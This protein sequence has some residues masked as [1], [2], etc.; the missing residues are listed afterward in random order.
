MGQPLMSWNPPLWVTVWVLG[1]LGCPGA[2]LLSTL[3]A[4]TIVLL[5]GASLLGFGII[6]TVFILGCRVYPVVAGLLILR[7]SRTYA[8]RRAW[9]IL[10]IGIAGLLIIGGIV[11]L[12]NISI[13]IKTSGEPH[14]PKNLYFSGSGV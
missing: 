3:I 1:I 9:K 11:P 13:D 8:G 5:S 10:S 4:F 7:A 12:L 14:F 6:L 2:F